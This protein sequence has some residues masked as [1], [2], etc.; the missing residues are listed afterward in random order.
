MGVFRRRGGKTAAPIARRPSHPRAGRRTPRGARRRTRQLLA[1]GEVNLLCKAQDQSVLLATLPAITR[2]TI[3]CGADRQTT[4]KRTR[5]DQGKIT[6]ACAATRMLRSQALGRTTLATGPPRL[7]PRRA[8]RSRRPGISWCP[9]PRRTPAVAGLTP[10]RPAS[11][12]RDYSVFKERPRRRR[13]GVPT[14]S[15]PSPDPSVGRGPFQSGPDFYLIRCRLASPRRGLFRRPI[16]RNPFRDLG[17]RRSPP[18][19]PTV[20]AAAREEQC[21][22]PPPGV[23]ARPTLF[24]APP[25]RGTYRALTGGGRTEGFWSRETSGRGRRGRRTRRETASDCRAS[26]LNNATWCLVPRVGQVRWTVSNEREGDVLRR[27][28]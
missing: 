13:L 26:L 21:T 8:A 18:S 1:A 15:G 3:P 22:V 7:S 23:N 17:L 14:S 10:S 11:L 20:A 4:A 25:S 2:R 19:R 28:L 16:R 12:S 27:A 5:I 24:F 9:A 6:S